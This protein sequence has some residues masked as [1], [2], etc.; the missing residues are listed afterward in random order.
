MALASLERNEEAIQAYQ[1]GLELEPGNTQISAALEELSKPKEP[2]NPFFNQ[3]AMAKLMMNEK[4]RKHLQD[5]DFKMKFEFCKTN[6]Q[7]M[8]QLMQS[9]PR[10]MDVFQVITGIN[11]SEMQEKTSKNHDKS[12]EFKRQRDLEKKRKE[13]EEEARR[14]QEEMDRM[15]DEEKENSQQLKLADEWKDKGNKSYKEKNFEEAIQNYNRAIEIYPAELTYYTNKAAVYFEIKDY[16]KCIEM[17]EQAEEIAK[18]GYYDFKKLA[19]ALARKANALFKAARYDESIQTYKRA[20]LEHNDPAYKDAMKKV[21]KV[22]SKAEEEAYIDPA[23]S[24]E[25]RLNGN[26]LFE[27]GNFPGAIKEYDE[28]LRRD[29]KN[30]KIFSNRA[31][32][33]IKLMEFPTA[34]KDIEKGLAIDPE[35]I[36]LWIRKARIHSL[37]KEYH[38]AMEACDKGLKIEPDNTELKAEKQKV[39]MMIATSAGGGGEDDEERMRHGMADPEIQ[40]LVKDYRIQQLLKEMNENP[41]AAQAKLKDSFYADA[42]N[43]LVAAGVL[44]IK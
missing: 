16:D 32:T 9:D 21:E 14:K 35:F 18:Q 28:G 7:M 23:K 37:M 19:K 20:M 25:H 4:T 44:K 26:K 27:E 24:E 29:P 22:K 2:E 10:F 13:E 42:V 17:C 38:K 43:K 40:M 39:I 1:K 34:M 6:P 41:M 12:E 30:I 36:K 5:P 33:Y 11:L 3:E 31:A 15:T 8:M